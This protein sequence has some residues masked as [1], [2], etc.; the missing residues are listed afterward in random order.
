MYL[1]QIFDEIDVFDALNNFKFSCMTMNWY[2]ANDERSK[3][4]NLIK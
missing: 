4:L 2:S 3:K 1:F